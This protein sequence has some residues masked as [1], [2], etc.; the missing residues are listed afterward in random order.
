GNRHVSSEQLCQTLQIAEGHYYNAW[1][2]ETAVKRLSRFPVF[3]SVENQ[4]KQD[5]NG[6]TV[7]ILVKERRPWSLGIVTQFTDFDQF[8]GLRFALNEHRSGAWRGNLQTLFGFQHQELLYR[9]NIEK[10]WFQQ[11]ALSIGFGFEQFIRSWDKQDYHFER[12]EAQERGGSVSTAYKIT[13]NATIHLG[14]FRKQFDPLKED[15]ALPV[16]SGFINALTARL[17]NRGRFL[18][19]GEFFFNWSSQIFLETS[20]TRAHGD[21]DYTTLQLNGYPQLV[22]SPA[23]TLSF[24]AHWGYSWGVPQQKLFSLGGDTTLPGY[25]DDAFVGENVFLLRARYDLNWG[26]WF[27]ETSRLAPS[28][29]SLLLDAGDVRMK[30]D[31]VEFDVPKLEFGIELNYA[32]VIRLGLVRSLGEEKGDPYFYFGWHPHLIRPRL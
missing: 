13:D 20:T 8:G 14:L 15:D 23:Q 29:V 17:T 1:E 12:Q 30:G 26:R 2:L 28:G 27:G 4:L 3:A 25:D 32:S 24:G 19:E 16:D 31:P 6:N 10:G 21:Y 5:A 22:L 7:K 18:R 9:V 11:E